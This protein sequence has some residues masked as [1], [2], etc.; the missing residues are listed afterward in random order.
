MQ[1]QRENIINSLNDISNFINKNKNL[2][3]HKDN[4]FKKYFS[5][6][7]SACVDIVTLIERVDGGIKELQKIEHIIQLRNNKEDKFTISEDGQKLRKLADFLRKNLEVDF[8]S[9]Y[10]FSKIF[11]DKLVQLFVFIVDDNRGIKDSSISNFKKSLDN[12]D[13]KNNLFLEFK[14]EFSSILEEIINYLKFYRD[15]RIVHSKINQSFTIWFVNDMDG[16]IYFEHASQNGR[17]IK[18]LSPKQIVDI[19]EKFTL[20]L[21]DFI[22]NKINL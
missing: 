20:Q 13:G 19:L 5:L 21:K 3:I 6:V 12:Y 14:K 11:L 17:N 15:K 10:I 8:K 1:K 2:K 9:L 16:N 22:V 4:K 7:L 18:S